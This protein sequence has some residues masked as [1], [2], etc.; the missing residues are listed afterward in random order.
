MK[1]ELSA[2]NLIPTLAGYTERIKMHALSLCASSQLFVSVL[3]I[4]DPINILK[5]H[6]LFVYFFKLC[7]CMATG[8]AWAI[9]KLQF[10]YSETSLSGHLSNKA[11]S[12]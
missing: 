8:T 7:D 6:I 12:L 10:N 2:C 3:Y 11:T 5:F 9:C 4:A 1:G